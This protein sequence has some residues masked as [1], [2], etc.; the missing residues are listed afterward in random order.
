MTKTINKRVLS[1]AATAAI[2][3]GVA[4]AQGPGFGRWGAGSQTGAQGEQN[5][6]AMRLDRMSALLNLDEGQKV[7]AKTIFDNASAAHLA[8]QPAMLQAQT[9]LRDAARTGKDINTLAAAAGTLVGKMRAIQTTASAQFYNI[10]TPAQRE[11][12]DKHEA[13]GGV[14]MGGNCQQG[15]GMGM[16]RGGIGR[17]ARP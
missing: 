7:Q 2:A 8:L 13:A 11:T 15:G 9:A 5:M 14:C 10:L 3:V 1:I 16:M 6:A 12:L 4:M 17:G